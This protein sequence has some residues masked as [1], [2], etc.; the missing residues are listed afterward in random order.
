MSFHIG[1]KEE[2]QQQIVPSQTS[3]EDEGQSIQK[4]NSKKRR[5]S[6]QQT[7]YIM[8]THSAILTLDRQN[9]KL[10]LT[11]VSNLFTMQQI[12]QQLSN[13]TVTIL[14]TRICNSF[15]PS[16]NLHSLLLFFRISNFIKFIL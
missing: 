10:E 3:T 15:Q 6:S 11:F 13:T 7:S 8:A 1:Q 2:K 9:K 16:Q 14:E 5:Q 12:F 4:T